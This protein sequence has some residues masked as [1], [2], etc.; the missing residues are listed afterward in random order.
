MK[1]YLTWSSLFG[2][3]LVS[4]LVFLRNQWNKKVTGSLQGRR[5]K[6][7]AA[8]IFSKTSNLSLVT[9]KRKIE[10]HLIDGEFF[11]PENWRFK[12]FSFKIFY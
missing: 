9:I 1:E 4:V 5:N 3:A 2:I 10:S 7:F 11:V 8:K 6:L 12:R